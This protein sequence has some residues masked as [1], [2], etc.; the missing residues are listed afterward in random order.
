MQVTWLTENECSCTK[1]E[2][3]FL[4]NR[5]KLCAITIDG[6]DPELFWNLK[7]L[8]IERFWTSLEPLPPQPSLCSAKTRRLTRPSFQFGEVFLGRHFSTVD[9]LPKISNKF[10]DKSHLS[11]INS[12]LSTICTNVEGGMSLS[13]HTHIRSVRL[14]RELNPNL[15]LTVSCP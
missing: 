9:N 13:P 12:V 4:H 15:W 7:P 8:Y 3:N 11:H 1:I 2:K 6:V 14:W 5:R 10:N